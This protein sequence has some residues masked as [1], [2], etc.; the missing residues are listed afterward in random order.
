MELSRG[1]RTVTV[2]PDSA[3]GE[4]RPEA[5]LL[6]YRGCLRKSGVI[7]M[8]YRPLIPLAL[9]AAGVVTLVWMRRKGWVDPSKDRVRRGTG[10]ALLGLQEFV[11]PSVEF[12]FQAENAEQ[13]EEDDLD[14]SGSGPREI[15]ADLATSLGRDPLDHEEVRR[16][17]ASARRAGLDWS[18]AYERAVG[19]ELTTRPYRAPSLPPS[20]R[21]APR[22]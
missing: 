17:L 20:W 2:F 4:K 3:R 1:K 13:T 6:I 22:E 9:L 8:D 10:H 15:L 14:A 11:E 5:R 18:E 21:V 12:I 16:H 7:G 19:D